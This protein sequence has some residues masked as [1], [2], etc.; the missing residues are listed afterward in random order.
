[1]V[2]VHIEHKS[3]AQA[4]EFDLFE[5]IQSFLMASWH[6]GMGTKRRDSAPNKLPRPGV[7]L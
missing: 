1:M 2:P 4:A 7:N 6:H 3:V 5:Y